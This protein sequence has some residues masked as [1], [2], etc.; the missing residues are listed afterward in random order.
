VQSITFIIL[1]REVTVPVVAG[2]II[3]GV[4]AAPVA[5]R[6]VNKVSPRMLMFV[7]GLLICFLQLRSLLT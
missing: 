3:G 7:V 5:A 2:L 4:I 6:L 1:L